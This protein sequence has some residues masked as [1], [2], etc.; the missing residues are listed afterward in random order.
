M[1]LTYWI[2]YSTSSIFK[3]ISINWEKYVFYFDKWDFELIEYSAHNTDFLALV[4]VQLTYIWRWLT[5]RSS[6]LFYSAC[7]DGGLKQIRKFFFSNNCSC[8]FSAWPNWRKEEDLFW[9]GQGRVM[10]GE[11]TLNSSEIFMRLKEFLLWNEIWTIPHSPLLF[12]EP[13]INKCCVDKFCR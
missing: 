8:I 11:I 12:L 1:N 6:S 10:Q 13:L 2:R 5:K 7:G 3:N 4:K 9:I